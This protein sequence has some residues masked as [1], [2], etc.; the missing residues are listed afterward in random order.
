M[1]TL[2]RNLYLLIGLLVAIWAVSIVGFVFDGFV[3][4]FALVP[5]E[6]WHLP[7]ILGMH[8]LHQGFGHL[9]ANTV[10]LAAFGALLLTRGADY[11]L[12]SLVLV[13]VGGGLLLWLF[14]RSA[15]HI[16]ASGL[17]F[18]LFGLLV[19]RAV[20]AKSLESMLI[21]GVVML[22]YGGLIWGVLPTDSSVSWDGHLAGLLAGIAAARLL[23]SPSTTRTEIT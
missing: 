16:G 8:F 19:A 14:G 21:A 7:G 20:F 23:D 2:K 5:R 10:P 9:I 11:F 12:R 13:A 18:G 22:G 4:T 6:F 15:A 3:R 1:A 17:V